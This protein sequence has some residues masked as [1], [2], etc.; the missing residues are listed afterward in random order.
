MTTLTEIYDQIKHQ[1]A[2]ETLINART[3]L[4]KAIRELD[5]AIAN[6][7]KADSNSTKAQIM[8]WALHYVA[9]NILPNVRLDLMADAQAEFRGTIIDSSTKES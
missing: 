8:N 5:T 7:D 1:N 2:R 6:L 9:C 3:I 4:E